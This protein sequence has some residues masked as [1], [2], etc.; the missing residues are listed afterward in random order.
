MRFSAALL[1]FTLGILGSAWPQDNPDLST[2]TDTQLLDKLRSVWDDPDAVPSPTPVVLVYEGTKIKQE[3]LMRGGDETLIPALLQ[4]AQGDQD[5]RADLAV[6]I[7]GELGESQVVPILTTQLTSPDADRRRAAFNELERLRDPSSLPA[8]LVYYRSNPED[9]DRVLALLGKLQA[10]ELIPE[11]REMLQDTYRQSAA[12]LALA[13]MGDRSGRDVARNILS[14]DMHYLDLSALRALGE[15]GDGGDLGLI[16]DLEKRYPNEP[17]GSIVQC[18]IEIHNLSADQRP[19]HVARMLSTHL[20]EE[21]G[22]FVQWAL[23]WLGQEGSP[24]SLKALQTIALGPVPLPFRIE[25]VQQLRHH[26]WKALHHAGMLNYVFEL[27][28][29]DPKE[30]AK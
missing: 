12:A 8:L 27:T 26:G 11:C 13:E 2:W 7:L 24:A 5:E 17:Q 1:C 19:G 9:P 29:P 18:Q 23:D 28:E 21:Q 16:R 3:I 6:S 25:A 20:G 30:G 4:M 10:T 14:H 22:P 15:I